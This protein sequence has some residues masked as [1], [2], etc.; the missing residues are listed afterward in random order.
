M[1][2]PCPVCCCNAKW[3]LGPPSLSVP[4]PFS[5]L[6]PGSN[7]GFLYCPVGAKLLLGPV[8][9][10]PLCGRVSHVP[11][12]VLRLP[13]T[14]LW[15]QVPLPAPGPPG[16]QEWGVG[17]VRGW[18]LVLQRAAGHPEGATGEG[19]ESVQDRQE[20]GSDASCCSREGPACCCTGW[21]AVAALC[22]WER[23]VLMVAF[24]RACVHMQLNGRTCTHFYRSEKIQL[25]CLPKK[26]AVVKDCVSVEECVTGCWLGCYW[27]QPSPFFFFSFCPY[28]TASML[29]CQQP[30]NFLRYLTWLLF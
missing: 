20:T 22:I 10:F 7:P 24:E 30:F 3:N 14:C 26:C 2:V 9:V 17:Q 28:H 12:G 4:P 11:V 29:K 8:C 15:L 27:H 1:N 18:T 25:W 19:G 13:P 5:F 6:H 23:G 16:L 21:Q